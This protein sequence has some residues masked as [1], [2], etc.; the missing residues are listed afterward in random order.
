MVTTAPVQQTIPVPA[1]F[2]VRWKRPDDER[3]FWQIDR[4]HFP[5]PMT[6]MDFALMSAAHEQF[7]WAFASY[8]IPLAFSSRHLNYRWYL[9]VNPTVTDPALLL[10]QMQTGL[11]N[12]SATMTRLGS[13]WNDAW[14]PEVKEHLAF[15]DGFDLTSALMADLLIH[16]EETLKRHNRVWQ[17]HFLQTFPVYMA[18]SA[19][20]DLYQDLFNSDN[21]L[22]AYQLMQGLPNKTVEMGRALWQLSRTVLASPT[23]RATFDEAADPLLAL[24]Q[25][26]EGQA[27]LTDFE[28]FL[29]EHGRRGEQLGVSHMTWREDPSQAIAHLREYINQPDFDFDAQQSALAA[30]REEATAIARAR[31]AGY[32]RTIIEQF[33]AMLAAAQQA[34]IISED[35]NAYIDFG[36]IDRVRQVLLEFGRRFTRAGIIAAPQDIFMLT[37][38]ELRCTSE[39][40]FEIDRTVLVARRKAE[41]ERSRRITPPPALGT[42]PAAPPP[43]DPLSRAIGKFFGLPAAE[44]ERTDDALVIHGS[45]GSSGKVSG[46]ARVILTLDDAG[47]LAE[48]DILVA[49]TT[50]PAWTPLFATAAAIVTDTG[51]VLSH[52]AVVAREYRIP[53]VVGT[54]IGTTVIQ[55][56]DLIEVDGNAGTVSIVRPH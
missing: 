7:T 1:N 48:G 28:T 32:P 17:I 36:A 25:T 10:S 2:P 35:H 31:L 15:W 40:L 29:D 11:E 9:S 34:T 42:L 41:M 6:P 8:G 13:L 39:R 53:A 52:S 12:L 38:A 22:S 20:E 5:D 4:M 3:L 21:G 23:L 30:E 27:F 46:I 50:A 54:G 33:E 16:F 14:L 45:S 19:F 26:P 18:M 55:D 56:G 44:P 24:A 43:D 47:R 37:P 51:G 49:P